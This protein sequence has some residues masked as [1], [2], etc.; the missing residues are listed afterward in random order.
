VTL[1]DSGI[2]GSQVGVKLPG[3][4]AG[5]VFET[6]DRHR[7]ILA[8]LDEVAVGITHVATPFPVV[9][10]Q[11]LGKE[12]RSFV[13]PSPKAGPNVGDAQV[14]EAIRS[15]GI[16]RSFEENLWLVGSRTT[17]GIENDSAV[18]HLDVAGI[19]RL[20]HFPAKNSDV[21][22]L[23][24]FLIPHDEEVR[25]EEAFLCNRCIG[26]IHTVSPVVDNRIRQESPGVSSK[27]FVLLATTGEPPSSQSRPSSEKR[28]CRGCGIQDRS[29]AGEI[30]DFRL[31]EDL[32]RVLR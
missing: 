32:S 7:S 5:I 4:S 30:P 26:Q 16:R 11:R 31:I 21:E 10:L 6:V 17:T 20:D 14:K 27:P 1:R 15:V 2:V 13:A 28:R 3:N 29:A 22:V 25:D 12:E 24:F 18:G 19:F 23:R 9:I 8:D